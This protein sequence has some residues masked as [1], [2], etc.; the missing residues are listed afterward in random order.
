MA[1]QFGHDR[2]VISCSR[3]RQIEKTT[4]DVLVGRMKRDRQLSL[5]LAMSNTVRSNKAEVSLNFEEC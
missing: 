3:C 1:I 5:M 4:M 2:F